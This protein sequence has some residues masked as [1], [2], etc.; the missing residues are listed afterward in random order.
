MVLGLQYCEYN[1]KSDEVCDRFLE[2]SENKNG[3]YI[4]RDLLGCDIGT[5]EGVYGR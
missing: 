5:P 2:E 3:S 1:V 4:C